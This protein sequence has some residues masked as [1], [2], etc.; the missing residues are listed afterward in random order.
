M[1]EE[2]VSA[3][4]LV[5]CARKANIEVVACRHHKSPFWG[6]P[7]G[8]PKP[9]ETHEQT[10]VREVGEET[11]L[12]VEIEMLIDSIYYWFV[13]GRDGIRYHKT[14]FFY[15]MTAIGGDFSRH[16]HEFEEVR[17]FDATEALKILKYDNEVR[18]LEKGLSLVS[19]K[20]GT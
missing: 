18:V 13:G 20:T 16:D 7:K 12:V 14:V 17:W 11:G 6:L 9:G 3:G 2:L 15:L 5:Y 1:V 10:A 4:G 8:T 19:E